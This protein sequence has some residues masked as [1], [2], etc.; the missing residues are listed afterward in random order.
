MTVRLL[1]AHDDIITLT[2]EVLGLADG[3]PDRITLILAMT[4]HPP[5]MIHHV[6]A[7]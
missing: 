7:I 1:D 3:K 5:F 4:Y 2:V 6:P